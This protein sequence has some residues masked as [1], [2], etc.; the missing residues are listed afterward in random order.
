MR[1]INICQVLSSILYRFS[2]CMNIMCFN[3]YSS[4]RPELHHQ[5]VI[6]D[7]YLN[8]A[9]NLRKIVLLSCCTDIY[10]LC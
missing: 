9:A 3:R 4:F 7:G 6:C 5:N 2:I 8:L 1:R 10:I